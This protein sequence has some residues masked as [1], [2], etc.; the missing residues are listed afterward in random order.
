M[1][2]ADSSVP[3][4]Y[5]DFCYGIDNS[6]RVMIP[7]RWRPKDPKVVFTAILWPINVEDYLLVLPPERWQ[8]I[9]DKLKG[10]SLHDPGRAV[11]ERV[12]GA[13]SEPL[14]LDKV[15]RFCLPE[16]L[17][18]GAALQ[19]E[20]QF[21]GRVNKFEIWSPARYKTTTAEDKSQAA[22]VAVEIDL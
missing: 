1:P 13:T 19:K 11:L 4:F 3:N 10:N 12:I 7:A 8:M 18:K 20:A 2:D 6:R 21:V 5:G 17:A 9:L 22:S 14:V 16:H 15:G